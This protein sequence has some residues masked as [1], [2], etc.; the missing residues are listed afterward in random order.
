MF[1]ASWGMLVKL[2]AHMNHV[3]VFARPDFG[4]VMTNSLVV[5]ARPF[6]K[7]CLMLRGRS[8]GHEISEGSWM[9]AGSQAS[10][11]DA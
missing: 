1:D 9:H 4:A 7:V 2:V 6:V 5:S 10:K 3:R 11:S 8:L